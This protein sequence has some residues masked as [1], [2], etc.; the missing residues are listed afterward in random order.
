MYPIAG[1]VGAILGSFANVCIVRIPKGE[2]VISPRSH[3]VHCW[4][5]LSWWENI[6]IFGYIILRGKCRKCSTKISPIYPLVEFICTCLALFAWW[7]FREPLH[8]FVYVC[9]FLI[10]LVVI[11]FIDLEH[12]IIPDSI[13]ITGIFVGMA[14][15]IA[16]SRGDKVAMGVSSLIGM[17]AGGTIVAIA[18]AVYAKIKRHPFEMIIELLVFGGLCGTII[19]NFVALHFEYRT[20]PAI[21]S[22]LGAIIGGASLYFVAFVYEKLKKQEGLGGGDIKLIAMLGAFLGWQSSIFILLLSSVA[23][24]MV[25]LSIVIATRKNMKYAIPFGPFLAIAGIVHLF[26]G[27]DILGW[28]LG[29]LR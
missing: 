25:G 4:H 6:P 24:S 14:V 5:M 26:I 13:S 28:Y 22:G 8:F 17:I 29:L 19:A 11:T 1:V 3:C 2:S 9:L 16:F 18:E 12:R 23:G 20:M 10:P 7:H 27:K 21:D 15:S